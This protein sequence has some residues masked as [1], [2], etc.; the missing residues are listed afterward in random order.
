MQIKLNK[1][2]RSAVR[3][4][5]FATLAALVIFA[6]SCRYNHSGTFQGTAQYEIYT[7]EPF[8]K[9]TID[10][11]DL[12][13]TLERGKTSTYVLKFGEKSPI[14]CGLT[15]DNRYYDSQGK[16]EETEDMNL[17][18]SADQACKVLDKDGNIK[19][20]H[21]SSKIIGTI[22]GDKEVKRNYLEI[23]LSDGVGTSFKFIFKDGRRIS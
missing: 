15:V 12:T 21:V 11:E 22:Y 18:G 20:A 13:F 8:S 14:Q 1:Y 23:Q 19:T 16:G 3:A 9:K 2:A 6:A 10:V 4:A 17:E 5:M 7:Y